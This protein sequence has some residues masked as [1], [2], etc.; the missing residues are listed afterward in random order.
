MGGL[1]DQWKVLIVIS[2][3][4]FMVVLDTTIVNIALPKIAASFNATT[5]EAEL[6]LT[7]YLLAL[8]AMIPATN[9]LSQRFGTKR[10]YLASLTGFTVG[11]AL[12]AVAPSLGLLEGARVLQG[13]GG[14]MIQPLGQSMLFQVAPPEQRGRLL[15]LYGLTLTLGPV[16][17]PT[18]GGY[19]T[20]FVHWSLVFS[21]NLPI[22]V[23]GVLLGLLLLR[24]APTQRGLS[25]DAFGFGLAAVCTSAALL[26]ATNAPK[27][28][29]FGWTDP[30]VLHLL[31]VSAVTLPVFV[32]WELRTPQPILDLRLFAGFAFSLNAVLNA[33]LTF[34]LYAALFLLP[35]FL[36]NP[37]LRNLGAW[38]AGLLLFWQGLGLAPMT[39]IAGRLYNRVGPRL[40]IISGLLVMALSN[41]ELT[42]LDLGTPDSTLRWI[43]VLRGAGIGLAFITSVTAW[44]G[45]VPAE[46]TAQASTLANALRN[47]YGSYATAI[48]NFALQRR[49]DFHYAGLAMF[50]RLDVPSVAL[51]LNQAQQ[52]ALA[53]GQSLAQAQATIVAQLAN[54]TQVAAMLQAYDDCF[55]I[56]TIACVL[57]M[58]PSLLVRKGSAGGHGTVEV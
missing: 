23:L 11:S 58:V 24:E 20:E 45:S 34:V 17:G 30:R 19:L 7:G 6:V 12:C 40:L 2:I 48:I 33:V 49:T 31:A 8:A 22:G 1:S 39:V 21:V 3:G 27:V 56:L 43:L 25:F 4:T 47:V 53:Q 55:Y 54:L 16:L 38:D 35:V 51:A 36:Q 41:L 42:Q 9:Y 18:L 14:A 15:G 32:W 29:Y 13:L 28:D 50:V 44:L 10:A 5:D 52:A 37:S 57:A 26:A 46:R